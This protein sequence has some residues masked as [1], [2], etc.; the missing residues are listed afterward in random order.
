VS[1]RGAAVT[2]HRGRLLLGLAVVGAAVLAAVFVAGRGQPEGEAVDQ[3]SGSESSTA[4]SADDEPVVVRRE[5]LA[6]ELQ[7]RGQTVRA[8]RE[9]VL[10]PNMSYTALTP[11]GTAVTA[12][13]ALVHFE[14]LAADV[15]AAERAVEDAE[16]ALDQA[17]DIVPPGA[18]VGDE[19]PPVPTTPPTT[20]D[21]RLHEL[22][23]SR[24]RA[25]LEALLSTAGDANAPVAGVVD[26]VSADRVRLGTG[27][28]VTAPLRPLQQ[29]RLKSGTVGA[30][31][32]IELT[33]GPATVPCA[34]VMVIDGAQPA[35]V[36]TAPA[37]DD[38]ESGDQGGSEASAMF[39][40]ALAPGT[41]TVGG[42]PAVLAVEIV[43]AE[44]SLLVPESAIRYDGDKPYVLRRDAAGVA[45][46]IEITLGPS[47]GIQRVVTGVDEG[48]EILPEGVDE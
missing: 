12:G 35:D 23:L 28:T 46:E 25:D 29:L 30:T 38:G 11:A 6:T 18:P 8:T 45:Q 3:A 27:Y 22:A 5:D 40:C 15:L 47:D 14:P 33:T 16:L 1:R 7:L 13:Q 19:P 42:L 9:I 43:F 44:Q 41:A 48:D 34:S 36:A 31:A 39:E 21:L 4:E 37:D 32:N 24:S 17:D 26:A 10:P 2:G 20:A